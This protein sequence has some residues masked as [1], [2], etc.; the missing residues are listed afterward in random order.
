MSS[1]TCPIK[2]LCYLFKR[3]FNIL[4][5]TRLLATPCGIFIPRGK[6]IIVRMG[7]PKF[8]KVE[9]LSTT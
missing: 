3:E 4:R 5:G 1:M 8:R 7:A 2:C 9:K 6:G